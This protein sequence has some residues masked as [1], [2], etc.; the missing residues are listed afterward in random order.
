MEI[1]SFRQKYPLYICL[2]SLKVTRNQYYYWLK[3]I[4]QPD[5]DRFFIDK[6]KELSE[7]YP[8]YGQNRLYQ[9]MRREGYII[10]HKKLSRIY[11]E[12]ALVL[13]VKKK[14]PKKID[15]ATYTKELTEAKH[16]NHVWAG[17][18]LHGKL[19]D[20]RKYYVF[21]AVDIYSRDIVSWAIGSSMPSQKIIES[22]NNSFDIFGKPK[23]FRSDNG[24]QFRSKITRRF[25]INERIMQEYI[26]KG[27]PYE[28]GFAESLIGKTKEE[29]FRRHIFDSIDDIIIQ[30]KEY[31][32]FFNSERL[33]KSLNYKT[34]KE[35]RTQSINSLLINV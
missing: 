35:V 29:F 7:K 3:K 22:L 17:D 6:I 11:R 8:F 1:V 16:I 32:E 10:N 4:N 18:I 26:E 13:P 2:K 5:K 34:P 24:S 27:K 31:V 14:K 20:K 19:S 28:N 12:L 30:W 9:Q 25:F 23:I 15:S 21:I 33:H